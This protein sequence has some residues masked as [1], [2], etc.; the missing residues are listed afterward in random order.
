MAL[1]GWQMNIL[2]KSWNE[3]PRLVAHLENSHSKDV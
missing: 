1:Y 2:D 3:P